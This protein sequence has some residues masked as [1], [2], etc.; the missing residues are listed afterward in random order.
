MLDHL[1]RRLLPGTCLCCG[2]PVAVTNDTDLCPWCLDALPWNHPACPRCARPTVAPTLCRRCDAR[3]PPF[4]HAVAPLRY[5]GQPGHWVRQ[6]KDRLGMVEGRVLGMLLAEAAAR[7]YRPNDPAVAAPQC[8]DAL[9]PVPLSARRLAWRGHNQ[10]ISLALP[11]ARRLGIPLL[12][13]TATRRPGARHQRGL[14]RNARLQNPLGAFRCRRR[15]PPPGPVLALVDDV[16]TTGATAAE[17]ARVLLEAGA[18]EVHVLAATR[19][20]RVDAARTW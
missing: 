10:A 7:R 5:E 15:W 9:V 19:S 8:P 18:R 3:P 13:Y 4:R 16:L 1:L 14:S 20:P 2:Q 11:V 6:L 17:L 12:R